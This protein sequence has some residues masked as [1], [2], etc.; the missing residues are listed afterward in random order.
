MYELTHQIIRAYTFL[1]GNFKNHRTPA[2][3][4]LQRLQRELRDNQLTHN[5]SPSSSSP[6]CA[7]LPAARTTSGSSSRFQPTLAARLSTAATGG[8]KRTASADDD[9]DDDVSDDGKRNIVKRSRFNTESNPPAQTSPSSIWSTNRSN[10]RTRSPNRADQTL[11]SSTH[12]N[13]TSPSSRLLGNLYTFA[14]SVAK[15]MTAP[16]KSANTLINSSSSSHASPSDSSRNPRTPANN[17]LHAL[18]QHLK[19]S[20]DEQQ[21][22]GGDDVHM[23]ST[24]D[25][26]A[27]SEDDGVD[28]AVPMDWDE[29]IEQAGPI[30]NS[31]AV[32]G[33]ICVLDTNVLVHSMP[34]IAQIAAD[35][36]RR[37]QQA[38]TGTGT[39][40]DRIRFVVPYI[41]L[42]ELDGLKSRRGGGDG[43]SSTARRAQQAIRLVHTAIRDGDWRVQAERPQRPNGPPTMLEP[44]RTN[45]DRILNCALQ[46]RRDC[47]ATGATTVCL[48]SDDVNLRNFA[49]LHDLEALSAEEL[50][51][52]WK[53]WA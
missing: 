33:R 6:T 32:V 53:C 19:Q 11:P 44:I 16:F 13:T 31:P 17:R 14:R 48:L 46:V 29:C 23:D 45:D 20:Q 40:N 10:N 26:A 24:S 15:S 43:H 49:L 30:V 21:H 4:R 47:G 35:Q 9:R 52:K 51:R 8:N 34:L 5:D 18:R 41:V 3:S 38:A 27:L 25:E 42:T 28:G 39:G 12:A 50:A 36:R 1:A 37:Q 7:R 2:Q 22:T